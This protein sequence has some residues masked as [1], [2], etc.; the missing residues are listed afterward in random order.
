[1]KKIFETHAHYEDEQFSD[2]RD[3]VLENIYATGVECIVNV[4]SD[5]ETSRKSMALASENEKIYAAVGIHPTYAASCNEEAISELRNMCADKKVVAIGEIG[6][7]YY[8]DDCPEDV[9]K[10]AFLKQLE[11]AKELDMPIIIHSRDACED[12]LRILRDFAGDLRQAGKK[13]KA[14]M[15]CFSYSPEIAKEYIDLGFYLGV[16]GVV[17]FKNSKK[18]VETVREIP[19][20][21]IVLETDSPYLTPVPFRGKRNDSSKLLYVLEKIAEIKETDVEEVSRITWDNSCRL[22]QINN[23]YEESVDNE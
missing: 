16:G 12:T 11:L 15:H 2:D 23:P 13:I 18:L 20:E 17:T 10:E 14:V 21:R 4:G 7:D 9:Q 1:M 19:L 22:Y 8:W 5:M 6:L 3:E